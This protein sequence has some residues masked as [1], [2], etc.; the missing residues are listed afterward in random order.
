MATSAAN[1]PLVA[2]HCAC[3]FA[4]ASACACAGMISSLVR[5][6]QHFVE[7][8]HDVLPDQIVTRERN[9]RNE[10]NEVIGKGHNP[11]VSQPT[12]RYLDNPYPGSKYRRYWS[13]KKRKGRAMQAD[14][15]APELMQLDEQHVPGAKNIR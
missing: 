13:Q 15:D 9:K 5:N 7:T 2:Y 8:A 6:S 10:E 12:I 3:G 4:S 11:K 14:G 1:V